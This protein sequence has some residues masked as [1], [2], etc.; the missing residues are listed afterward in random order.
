[1]TTLREMIENVSEAILDK[2]ISAGSITRKLNQAI[3]LCA[4]TTLLS[5]LESNGSFS[6]DPGL[7]SVNIPDSW[8]FDRN[9]YAASVEGQD[10]ITVYS[11]MALLKRDYPKADVSTDTGDVQAITVHKGKLF[12]FPRPTSAVE[13]QCQFYEKPALLVNANDTPSCIPSALHESILEQYAL[14]K[15]YAIIEDGTEG[16]KVNTNYYRK[17]YKEAL[18]TLDDFIEQGQSTSSPSRIGGRD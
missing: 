17:E 9:L 16:F 5:F 2:S 13:I 12:Y 6:T 11:S 15:C 14:W 7:S 1:M 10:D 8:N 4:Q 3:A 18:D